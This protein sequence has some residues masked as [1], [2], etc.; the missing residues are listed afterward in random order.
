VKASK[1]IWP[2]A[3]ASAGVAGRMMM[4][5]CGCEVTPRV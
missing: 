3:G 4:G 1:Q 2:A 5:I